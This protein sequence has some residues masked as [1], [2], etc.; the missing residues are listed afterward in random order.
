MVNSEEILAD[1]GFAHVFFCF[2]FFKRKDVLM[3]ILPGSPGGLNSPI[4]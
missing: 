2:V 3:S 4:S 1:L